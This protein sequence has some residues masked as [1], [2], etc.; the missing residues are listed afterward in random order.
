MSPKRHWVTLKAP[1]AFLR[2]LPEF[3]APKPKSRRTVAAPAPAPAPAEPDSLRPGTPSTDEALFKADR[4]ALSK[5]DKV[6][7][8]V[9]RPTQFKTFTGFKV[10]YEKWLPEE[11]KAEAA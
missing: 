2:T 8:W 10:E 9:R 7:K 5:T 1:P 4:A 11:P 6:R 3:A